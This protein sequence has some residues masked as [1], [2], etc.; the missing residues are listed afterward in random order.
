MIRMHSGV[1]SAI[2][3]SC[4]FFFSSRRRHTRLQGDWSSDVCSSDLAQAVYEEILRA[5]AFPVVQLSPEGAAAAFYELANDEQLE[6]IP[7][8]AAW[9]VEQADRKSVV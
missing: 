3:S 1:N 8:T 2:L 5:G 7:P 9:A 4:V 6:W